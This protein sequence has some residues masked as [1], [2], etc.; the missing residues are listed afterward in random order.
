MGI[1]RHPEL[2]ASHLLRLLVGRIVG[3]YVHFWAGQFRLNATGFRGVVI[4]FS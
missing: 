3:C 1:D 2:S 4:V